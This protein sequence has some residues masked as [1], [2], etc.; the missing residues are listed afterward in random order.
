MS[1]ER[2]AKAFE[3]R[4]KILQQ[5]ALHEDMIQISHKLKGERVEWLR[6]FAK[7][8]GIPSGLPRIYRRRGG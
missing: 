8:E 2:K 6:S 5:I 1:T 7:K 3:V 4:D